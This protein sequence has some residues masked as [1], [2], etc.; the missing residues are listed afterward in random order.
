MGAT[1]RFW[2]S[3]KILSQTVTKKESKNHP[4]R[5]KKDDLF[6]FE[7]RLPSKP[8]DIE[9]LRNCEIFDAES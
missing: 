5:L 7:Y 9:F 1:E 2:V 4:A 3:P 6:I 8:I